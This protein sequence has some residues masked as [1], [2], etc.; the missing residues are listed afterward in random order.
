MRRATGISVS[1]VGGR[2]GSI[3]HRSTC[4]YLSTHESGEPL[5]EYELRRHH[6]SVFAKFLPQSARFATQNYFTPASSRVS[7]DF[8][9]SSQSRTTWRS[10]LRAE[11]TQVTVTRTGSLKSPRT[12][13]ADYAR[14]DVCMLV[15]ILYTVA[16]RRDI[17]LES[18]TRHLSQVKHDP[19]ESR[20]HLTATV[21][22]HYCNAVCERIRAFWSNPCVSHKRSRAAY[23]SRLRNRG[24]PRRSSASSSPC[25]SR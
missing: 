16:L 7:M 4:I 19:T 9:A 20:R 5:H 11:M 6:R 8:T 22:S 18:E 13:T 21:P 24:F 10:S 2:D 14:L 23:R 12:E 1:E 3:A 15:S 25:S 17:S